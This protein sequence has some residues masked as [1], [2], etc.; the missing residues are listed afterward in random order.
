MGAGERLKSRKR[1]EQLFRE[2]KPIYVF[3]FR[4]HYKLEKNTAMA[5]PSLQCG[6]GVSARNFR[7]AVD[8]NR[9][10]RLVKEAYRQQKNDIKER[11]TSNQ[12]QLVLFFIYTGKELPQ[13]GLVQDKIA[14][15][16]KK[17]N[18]IV[19]ETIA[20]DT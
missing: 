18:T 16:L 1:T 11:L 2:G 6:F 19:D 14:V 20:S 8:R 13:A 5:A 9:V 7:R 15:I 3:P 10:K 4:V 17:L 12:L